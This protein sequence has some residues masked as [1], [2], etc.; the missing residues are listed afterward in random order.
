VF[1]E[2]FSEALL[3]WYDQA[4]R[5]LPWRL[6]V[7]NPYYTW[8]SEIM[9]QQTTVS[10]VIP[11]FQTFVQKWPTI[12]ALANASLQDILVAWQGL[13]YYSRARNLHAAAQA[14]AL[15]DAFPRTEEALRKLPGIG[16][17]TAAAIASIAFGQRAA[18]VDGNVVRVMSRFFALETPQPIEE[19]RERLQALLPHARCGDFT[20]ALMELGAL[21]CRV[22]NPQCTICPLRHRCAAY[23]LGKAEN[24][25]V[26]IPK[27]KIPTRTTTA[28][29]IRRAIDGA[30]LLRRRPLKGLL[31]GMMEVPST[32][33]E[34]RREPHE[35]TG[36]RVRHTFTHF[37]LE[38]DV[39]MRTPSPWEEEDE[40]TG[41]WV[42]PQD[43]KDHPLPTVIKKI[44]KA[45]FSGKL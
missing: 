26:K 8:L 3:F 17:Y 37:H 2:E 29:V 24:F 6:K 15:S 32:P 33:W 36:V 27:A 34:E 41:I 35:I 18:A 31:G 45:G 39:R 12:T 14:L 5:K 21:V 28:F 20:Q 4:Q 40:R 1:S 7:S 42:K 23:A 25:P 44:L 16:P 30:V 11:Y 38:I 19:V 22:K 9:L 10:T 43:L 13:G